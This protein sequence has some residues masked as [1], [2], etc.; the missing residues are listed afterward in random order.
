[1][2]QRK[3]T[4]TILVVVLAVLTVA[5]LA[6]YAFISTPGKVEEIGGKYDVVI[7]FWRRNNVVTIEYTDESG[8]HMG[9]FWNDTRKC[10]EWIKENTSENAVFLCW[11]DYGHMIKGYTGRDVIIR[12]PSKEIQKSVAN[13]KKVREYDPHERIVDVAR[14]LSTEDPNVTLNIMKKYNASYIFIYKDDLRKAGWIFWAA[15][16]NSSDY[17]NDEGNFTDRGKQTILYRLVSGINPVF[18]IAYQDERVKVYRAHY[19]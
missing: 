8:R 9:L 4:S 1:M 2:T 10:L 12:N 16:L 13:P 3:W 14:A 19:D 7:K 11:W 18:T 15:G 6:Y 17:I 5:L